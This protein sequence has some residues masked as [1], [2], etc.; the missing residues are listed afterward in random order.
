MGGDAAIPQ[1]L[2][3]SHQSGVPGGDVHLIG[4]RPSGDEGGGVAGEK[5]IFGVGGGP[6]KN[7]GIGIPFDGVLCQGMEEGHG[8]PAALHTGQD[9]QIGQGLVHDD[10]DIHRLSILQY[11][12]FSGV[13]PGQA[14]E[15]LRGVSLRLL[16]PHILEADGEIQH[17]AVFAGGPH[18]GCNLQSLHQTGAEEQSGIPGAQGAD[19]D[20]PLPG[21]GVLFLLWQQGNQH[22]KGQ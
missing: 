15:V 2:H 17:K 16:H 19:G 5:L 1:S 6:P 13:L 10:Y 11:S 14:G 9:G 22:Q 3:L 21:K 4:H 7:G 20:N 18:G 8:V 12:A